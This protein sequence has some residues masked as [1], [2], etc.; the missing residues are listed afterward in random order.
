MCTMDEKRKSLYKW[1]SIKID[2]P[3][4]IYK[5]KIGFN[6][7]MFETTSKCLNNIEM[8]ETTSRHLK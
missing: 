5:A 2:K 4:G 8:F 6:V 1:G 3:Y 7:S